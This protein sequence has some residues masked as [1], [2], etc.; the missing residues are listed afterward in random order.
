MKLSR[1]TFEH[2]NLHTLSSISNSLVTLHVSLNKLHVIYA[3]LTFE[4][5]VL[6]PRDFTFPY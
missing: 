6:K 5:I 2:R 4:L 1:N 3:P